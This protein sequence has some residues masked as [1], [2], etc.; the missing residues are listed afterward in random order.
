MKGVF[1]PAEDDLIVWSSR[2]DGKYTVKV[3]WIAPNRGEL[4]I[5]DDTTVLHREPVSVSSKSEFGLGV[6]EIAA[7]QEAAIVFVDKL[8]QS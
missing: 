7:W 6:G 1:M 5:A 4:S 2:L 8:E 3:I